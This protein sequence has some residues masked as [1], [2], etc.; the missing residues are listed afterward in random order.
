MVKFILIKSPDE[1]AT[2]KQACRDEL[3]VYL[4]FSSIYI[5]TFK[6]DQSVVVHC[7]WLVTTSLDF[8]PSSYPKKKKM[9]IY[10]YIY[11]Y[12]FFFFFGYEEGRK[13]NDVVTSQLQS[14]AIAATSQLTIVRNQIP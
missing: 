5:Y 1:W 2:T 13:S 12:F 6:K 8:R 7:N 3:R 4:S 9:Y 10:I 14:L 11:I